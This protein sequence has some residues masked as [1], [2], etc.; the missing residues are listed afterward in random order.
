MIQFHLIESESDYLLTAESNN[1]HLFIYRCRRYI[2]TDRTVQCSSTSMQNMLLKY[3]MSFVL[4]KKKSIR[5]SSHIERVHL[6]KLTGDDHYF[7]QPFCV[8]GCWF[9]H[10][11]KNCQRLPNSALNCMNFSRRNIAS[12]QS[13]KRRSKTE[14]LCFTQS[15]K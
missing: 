9:V 13:V 5:P 3:G 10:E 14:S 7:S 4:K 2:A 15:W 1:V 8:G 12:A 11:K 6:C